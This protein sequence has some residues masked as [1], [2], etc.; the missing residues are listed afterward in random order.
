MG[1]DLRL[2]PFDSDMGDLAFSHT[3][4]ECGRYYELHDEIRKLASARVPLKFY[5]F[6]G[7]SPEF[8]DA[9]YEN[10]QEDPYGDPVKYVMAGDLVKIDLPPDPHCHLKAV[11]AY[12][13]E[14]MPDTKVALYWH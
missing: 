4:L 3:V 11:W 12:L 6:S 8:D 14:L 7:R 13:R 9:C 2:L 1:I 10:T 5:S